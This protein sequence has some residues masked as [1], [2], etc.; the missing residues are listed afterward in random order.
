MKTKLFLLL[1][2]VC[3]LCSCGTSK[4]V[5]FYMLDD[6]NIPNETKGNTPIF[7]LENI[8][9]PGYLSRPQIATRKDNRVYYDEYNRW[10]DN[11]QDMLPQVLS[12]QINN[13]ANK[14]LVKTANYRNQIKYKLYVEINRFDSVEGKSAVLDAWWGI[15][16]GN[17]NIMFREHKVLSKEA[18]NNVD[19][20]VKAQSELIK[21]LSKVIYAKI[22]NYK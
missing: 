21:D 4:P 15:T 6:E 9:I 16:D 14:T 3:I 13:I 20:F 19:A 8:S 12:Y 2:I 18:G 17:D 22:K 1:G 5:K 10:G 11:L 7:L